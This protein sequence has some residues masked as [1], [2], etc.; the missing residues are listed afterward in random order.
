M[1]SRPKHKDSGIA[2]EVSF[3]LFTAEFWVQ[4]QGSARGMYGGRSGTGTGHLGMLR[5]PPANSNPT[6]VIQLCTGW[7]TI[8]EACRLPTLR[9]HC[10]AKPKY[11]SLDHFCWEGMGTPMALGVGTS[12][13]ERS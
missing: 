1:T 3:L 8:S 12:N 10:G 4:S 13:I 2:Q 11:S 5:F 9:T 7:T 6:P